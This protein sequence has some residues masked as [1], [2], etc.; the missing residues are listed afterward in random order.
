[1]T[2]GRDDRLLATK[3]IAGTCLD[4]PFSTRW[5]IFANLVHASANSMPYL[6]GRHWL[7][8]DDANVDAPSEDARAKT[9]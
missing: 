5:A 4:H 2:V 6:S 1:M 9:V 7:L 3:M 8:V